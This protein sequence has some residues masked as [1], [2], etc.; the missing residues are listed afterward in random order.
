M[1]YRIKIITY[2][3]GKKEF[4]PQ[5]KKGF[6]W[7]GLYIDGETTIMEVSKSTREDALKAI[8]AHY[9]GNFKIRTI[10]IEYINK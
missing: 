5:V 4:I 2:K 1:K 6:L 8:D 7:L 10:E 3:S 9:S